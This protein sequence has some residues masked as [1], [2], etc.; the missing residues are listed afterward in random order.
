MNQQHRSRSIT[1]WSQMCNRQQV[2]EGAMDAQVRQDSPPPSVPYV[3]MESFEWQTILHSGAPDWEQTS[4]FTIV[5]RLQGKDTSHYQWCSLWT[6]WN[7][8]Q[9][10]QTEE[11]YLAVVSAINDGVL[12]G[13]V[14]L[15]EERLGRKLFYMACCPHILEAIVGTTCLAPFLDPFK[16]VTNNFLCKHWQ[17]QTHGNCRLEIR[18]SK[19]FVFYC[20]AK[21][22]Q[23]SHEMTTVCGDN[24]DE[25]SSNYERPVLLKV[26]RMARCYSSSSIEGQQHEIQKTLSCHC[27]T[28]VMIFQLHVNFIK[29][30]DTDEEYRM[31]LKPFKNV[32]SRRALTLGW[33]YKMHMNHDE[34]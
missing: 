14:K 25:V 23:H 19:I 5:C 32:A 21:T 1:C 34:K 33:M 8:G 18:L 28:Q 22:Q 27:I 15:V 10:C 6:P 20:Q 26:R 24:T 11:Q 7:M 31:F 2:G 29:D 17:S 4:W 9:V 16:Q 30:H 12:K 3:E 13:A